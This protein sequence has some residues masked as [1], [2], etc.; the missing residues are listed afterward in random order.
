[1]TTITEV[2]KSSGRFDEFQE[3]EVIVEIDGDGNIQPVERITTLY[4]DPLG[5][6]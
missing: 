6:Y 5:E 4:R 2:G 1:M 3:S